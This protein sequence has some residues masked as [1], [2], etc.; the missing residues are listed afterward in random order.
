MG[1]FMAIQ[2]LWAVPWMMEVDG[3]TRAGAARHLLWM[4]VVVLAGYVTLGFFG[5][6]LARRGVHA[7]HMFAAGFA[8]RDL[9]A[10][11][12]FPAGARQLFLVVAVRAGIRGQRACVHR[13]ERRLRPR[14]RRP[15][16]HDAQPADV[17]RQ[18][19]PAMGHRRRRRSSRASSSAYDDAAG[20]R[21][22]F[23][24]VLVGNVLTYAWF[25]RGWRRHAS[26]LPSHRG[27]ECT[28][29]SSASAARSWAASRR[30]RSA[31]GTRSPD[32]TPTSIRRCPRN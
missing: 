21:L 22:A 27:P 13:V 9:R 31:P 18:L 1:S 5:T 29:T 15:H 26:L 12:H 23:G 17:R 7:R 24:L 6:E 11:R 8:H 19:R 30:S 14:S 2:G 3:Q 32:A 28:C 10:C 20:L 25:L 16:E 4:G